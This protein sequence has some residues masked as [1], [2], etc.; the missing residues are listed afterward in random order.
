MLDF[1]A[2]NGSSSIINQCQV[3]KPERKNGTESESRSTLLSSS[4]SSLSSCAG[5]LKFSVLRK[6]LKFLL[7]IS[8]NQRYLQLWHFSN[9]LVFLFGLWS[10]IHLI[11]SCYGTWGPVLEILTHQKVII[12]VFQTLGKQEQWCWS[13]AELV[14]VGAGLWNWHCYCYWY[15]MLILVFDIVFW[16][17]NWGILVAFR[18]KFISIC[19]TAK[20]STPHTAYQN[21]NNSMNNITKIMKII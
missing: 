15:F 6:K 14:Q 21:N 8:R 10:A 20:M 2:S 4:I 19:T 1:N 18:C 13:D 16:L 17:N 9:M 7:R 5:S 3:H 12:L 11:V